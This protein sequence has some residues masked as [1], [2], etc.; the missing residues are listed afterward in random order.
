[1][2]GRAGA[3]SGG[4][5]AG[6]RH[7]QRRQ[8]HVPGRTRCCPGRRCWRTWPGADLPRRRQKGGPGQRTGMAPRGRPAGFEDH[9]PHQ[10]SGGMRKRVSLAAALINEP[11]ILLMDE[12]F[13]ALDVQ[14][15][16]IMSNEL[17]GLWEQDPAL[18]P[19][20]H[21]RPGGGHRPRRPGGGDDRGAGHRQGG[22][23][24]RPAAATGCG[25]GD[26]LRARASSSCITRSG[27]RSGTR[28]S[29]PTPAP[30]HRPWTA[31]R[32][33][34]AP[35]RVK[36]ERCMS[37]DHDGVLAEV[38]PTRPPST[39]AGPPRPAAVASGPAR[40]R[41]APGRFL[42]WRLAAAPHLEGRRPVLLRPAQPGSSCGCGL[43]A[44]RHRLRLALAADLD[45]HE[46]GAARASSSGCSA[47]SCSASCWA[48]CASSPTCSGP[49]SRS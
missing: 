27:S 48:R 46:G 11:S 32:H 29:E 17:L 36:G 7:H 9:H 21:P 47:A 18:G 49:T 13:G 10:L 12:P 15:K 41:G 38:A 45:H 5:A 37:D 23:R 25:P 26:P 20:R 44:A 35:A 1:M 16:A 33:R 22:L 24:H 34:R 31:R 40:L 28:W 43:G 2:T 39:S 30:A 19:L 8:L 4:R 14:T 6:D 42:I 3:A